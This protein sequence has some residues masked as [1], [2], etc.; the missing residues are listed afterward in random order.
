[1]DSGKSVAEFQL[2]VIQLNIRVF[3]VFLVV[4]AVSMNRSYRICIYYPQV[5]LFFIVIR[6]D[7][8]WE[9]F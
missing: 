2:M 7:L 4:S 1:M 8:D 5:Q 9:L 6:E 3:H